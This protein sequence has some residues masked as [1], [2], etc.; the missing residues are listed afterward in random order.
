[1]VFAADTENTLGEVKFTGENTLT[2]ENGARLVLTSVA[3]ADDAVVNLVA[4]EQ[5]GSQSVRIG[6][7]K[8]LTKDELSRFRVNGLPVRRQSADG[9]LDLH[10]YGFGITI[11]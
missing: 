8:C 4:V 7:A 2:V 1:M 3:F 11:R 5:T 6:F 10:R 9:W